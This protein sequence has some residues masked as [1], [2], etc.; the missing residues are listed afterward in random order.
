M[1]VA[2]QYLEERVNRRTAELTQANSQ[3]QT[4]VRERKSIAKDLINSKR[5]YR[6]MVDNVSDY[7][8]VHDTEGFILEANH[9]ML[10]GLGYATEDLIGLN[11]KQLMAIE[12][13]LKFDQYIS[14]IMEQSSD[15]GVISLVAQDGQSRLLEFSSVIADHDSGNKAVYCLARD[16]TEKRL[17]DLALAES[18]ARFKDIFETAS[19]GMMIIEDDT[20]AVIEINPAAAQMFGQPAE[21]IKG[22]PINELIRSA[23][24]DEIQQAAETI[25]D[26]EEW[27]LLSKLD[28]PIPILKTM[29]PIEFDGRDHWVL[30]IN[31]LQKVKEA[32]YIKHEMQQQL[33]QSQHLQAI[34]TLAGGI[35]HDFNNILFGILGYTQLAM[36]DAPEGSLLKS[37]L[38]EIMKG[39]QRAMDLIAQILAF[40]RRG[41][42][43]KNVVDP[44]PLIN[45]ALKLLRASIPTTIEMKIDIPSDV[46][47]IYANTTQ[48]HQVVMNLCTNAAHALQPNGGLLSVVV[49]KIKIDT[50][51]KSPTGDL[52]QGKYLRLS[53]ID[54][55]IGIDRQV[56][57]RIFEPFFTTKPQGQGAGMGLSMVLG[58]VQDHGGAIRVSSHHGQGTRFDVFWPAVEVAGKFDVVDETKPMAGTEHILFVDDEFPLIQMGRQMLSRLGYKVHV[59]QNALE[60]F[61]FFKQNSN[62]IDLVITDLT[63]PKISGIELALRI[64]RTRS[65]L[66]IILCTGNAEGIDMEALSDIGVSELITKPIL[67]NDL[68][69]AIRNA[70]HSATR[71]EVLPIS[72]A[73]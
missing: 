39:G 35:A 54:N 42:A 62:L 32:E 51:E 22:Q 12:D 15:Q 36:D 43:E 50:E 23:K 69:K 33:M 18:Q 71:Q 47:S 29:R 52:K 57:N 9:R 68:A 63:M 38:G 7:I 59:F 19:A 66:P 8:C 1:S 27:E 37:N 31:S 48:L 30:S 61:D 44:S 10:V 21:M 53:V 55:G 6:S 58:I 24:Q 72:Q 40:G 14:R 49:E 46:Q 73:G 45:E 56:I 25:G 3:L 13:H 64:H 67:R 65:D 5:R 41:G 60:A 17:A 16:L 34:G 70:L 20:Q 11:M 26:P 4:E 28:G 2:N